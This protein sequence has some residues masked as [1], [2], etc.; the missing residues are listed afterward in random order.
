[1]KR[2]DRHLRGARQAAGAMLPGLALAFF[3]A[4]PLSAIAAACA[5]AGSATLSDGTG[6]TCEIT[7][8]AYNRVILTG[9]TDASSTG[10]LTV[11]RNS[12]VSDQ[13]LRAWDSASLTINGDLTV[14]RIG[15]QNTSA[16]MQFGQWTDAAGAGTG[17]HQQTVRVTGN[18]VVNSSNGTGV[19]LI[20]G[21]QT[22]EGNT[23]VNAT[24][25]GFAIYA[26]DGGG[27]GSTNVFGGDLGIQTAGNASALSINGGSSF[28]IGGSLRIAA[29]SPTAVNGTTSPG[30]VWLAS[31]SLTV[32]GDSQISTQGLKGHGILVAGR[33]SSASL[34]GAMNTVS[35]A[36]ANANGVRAV[37]GARFQASGEMA[38]DTQGDGAHGLALQDASRIAV[39][40]TRIA[41]RGDDA[42]G[43]AIAS[44]PGKLGTLAL[45]G[46]VAIE[47]QGAGSSGIHAVNGTAE[48]VAVPGGSSILTHGDAAHGLDLQAPDGD[49]AGWSV[50]QGARIET[51]GAQAD[52][53]Y[54]ASSSGKVNF[55]SAGDLVAGPQGDAGI[56]IA[57]APGGTEVANDGSIQ[58]GADAGAG[59][60]AQGLG[61]DAR[62]VNNG[63]IAKTGAAAA[64]TG[65]RA[66]HDG[67][68]GTL[69]LRNTGSL[70]STA[71]PVA[72]GVNGA[73]SS[74]GALLMADNS[75][76]IDAQGVGITAASE[77]GFD[78]IN[79][80]TVADSATTGLALS[81]TGALGG[82]VANSGALLARS[83]ALLSQT[84]G[85]VALTNSGT[86]R[87]PEAIR[88]TAGTLT[89]TNTATGRIEGTLQAAGG[90]LNLDNAGLWTPTGDSVLTHLRNSGTIAN[91][92][93]AAGGYKT[94]TATNYV[95]QGG[96]IQLNTWLGDDSS[97]SDRLVI[98]GGSASGNT[99]LG[100]RNTG[101]AGAPTTG[102][103]IL[104]VDARHNATT[105]GD[106]F[107]LAQ[108]VSAGAYDYALVRRDNQSWYLSSALPPSVDPAPS[109]DPKPSP[110]P[111]PPVD[112]P[113]YRQE[114]SLYAAVPSLAALHSAA[115]L[116]DF[117][118][119]MG[120]AGTVAGHGGH[121]ARLWTRL[122]ANDGERKGDARGIY[123]PNG[124]AYDHQTAALQLGGDFY[125]GRTAEG[126][127][128]HAGAYFATGQTTGDV[129]HF[130]GAAAGSAKLDVNSLGLYWTH[131]NAQGAYLDAVAQGSHYGI[132]ANSTRMPGMKSSG[133]GA[134]L[135]LEGGMP[136]HLG[137]AWALEPQ[138][139]LRR[140][141]ADL[142]S[143]ADLAGRIDYGDVDSLVGRAGL[144]LGYTTPALAG[145][146]RL[147][148]LNEFR[149][150]STTTVSSLAGLN[151]V[152]FDSSVHGTSA[153]L[154]AGVDAPLTQN[155]SL[156]GA[157][158]YLQAF[159]ESQG[160]AWGGEVGVK[161]AW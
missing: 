105:T 65:M 148:V 34:N 130:N 31:G 149:G 30:G 151:G 82:N 119:R 97:P 88:V 12:S 128:N 5:G 110:S 94:L 131:Q 124:P 123:G 157:A 135:S 38:I 143:G 92:A 8:S 146:A 93:P 129:T 9:S 107:S 26:D 35:T 27:A 47:T 58:F 3:A 156:Y 111:S 24:G 144:K 140:Q 132:A 19:R 52:P 17:L 76:R 85:N 84:A 41:T 14:S 4:H 42:F 106:A 10:S 25:G 22:F 81:G 95:G 71:A 116:D 40:S 153:A 102:N 114:T 63:A 77:G 18:T 86:L 48:P 138:L 56:F 142:G 72:D 134:D 83:T 78:L 89:A 141:V 43:I 28:D 50:A 32:A 2:I 104:L 64:G 29:T 121:A 11:T 70:G 98:D 1:M 46:A 23:Q 99:H 137:G 125:Q 74:P 158:Q 145:W 150:R 113:N 127:R 152:D 39:G 79:S 37:G 96:A 120:A 122:L 101:G 117:H 160:H 139:Q 15:A 60:S 108:P 49:V 109:P 73:V 45:N 36:G 54:L 53:V 62:I 59:I 6:K 16:T 80:G 133:H 103:G 13:A 159:G 57:S 20:G 68:A 66:A 154:S 112:A 91:T 87:A 61:G 21:H 118:Q 67:A 69:T 51:Q 90:Q 126:G 115:T 136:F 75:G 33:T 55:A 100:I 155:V 161:M 7:G 147:D 44:A